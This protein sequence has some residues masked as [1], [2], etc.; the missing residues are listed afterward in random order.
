MAAPLD[1]DR[2]HD[3]GRDGRTHPAPLH[4]PSRTVTVAAIATATA[5]AMLD[6]TPSK[7]Y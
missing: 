5:T 3:C 2:D 6:G 1:L 7:Y 4:P